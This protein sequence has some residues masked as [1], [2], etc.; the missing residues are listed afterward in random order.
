MSGSSQLRQGL[1]TNRSQPIHRPLAE[2]GESP[3]GARQGKIYRTTMVETSSVLP[4][5]DQERVYPLVERS[6]LPRRGAHL[7][8]PKRPPTFWSRHQGCPGDAF[9]LPLGRLA[10]Q[11]PPVVRSQLLPCRGLRHLLLSQLLVLSSLPP[12][13]A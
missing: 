6:L 5:V 7:T 4:P 2:A 8:Y 1:T 12:H 11:P 9:V 13:V 3:P 10:L